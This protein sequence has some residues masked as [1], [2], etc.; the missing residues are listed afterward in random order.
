V[1]TEEEH[2]LV[3]DDEVK[4]SLSPEMKFMIGMGRGVKKGA[5]HRID[6]SDTLFKDMEL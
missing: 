6:F 2:L 4:N 5:L 1:S 3:V